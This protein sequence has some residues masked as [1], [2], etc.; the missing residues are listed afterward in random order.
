MLYYIKY[1]VKHANFNPKNKFIII[2]IYITW[3]LLLLCT[4]KQCCLKCD[5]MLQL[6]LEL[7]SS[8]LE[9]ALQDDMS[10]DE[11]SE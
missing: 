6:S 3:L 2:T 8:G 4:I 7:V 1:V 5:K 11:Q 10:V 9:T